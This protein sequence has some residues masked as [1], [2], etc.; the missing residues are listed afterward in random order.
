MP[1]NSENKSRYG[2]AVEHL[3][4]AYNADE[5]T[6]AL[7]SGV[8][9]VVYD[10]KKHELFAEARDSCFLTARGQDVHGR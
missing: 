7:K 1:S 8:K 6:S 9:V 10:A 5:L 4:L 3:Q 2:V